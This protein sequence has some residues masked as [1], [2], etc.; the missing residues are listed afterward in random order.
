M[1]I[2]RSLAGCV[3]GL[4]L[5]AF[6]A[7]GGDA[8]SNYVYSADQHFSWKRLDRTNTDAVIINHL[9]L[10]SQKWRETVWN[11]HIKIVR[12]AKMRH[13]EFAFLF[14]T[15][16]GNGTS[17]PPNSSSWGVKSIQLIE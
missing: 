2:F 15:G 4:L 8:L 1:S 13:P 9:D 6:P 12:P 10:K 16:S 14:V 7:F 3:L 11:H 17:G 5:A